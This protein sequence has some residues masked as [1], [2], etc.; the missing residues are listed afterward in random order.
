MASTIDRNRSAAAHALNQAKQIASF[1]GGQR[2]AVLRARE[3][4]ADSYKS[5]TGSQRYAIRDQAAKLCSARSDYGRSV[6][7]PAH[8]GGVRLRPR[9]ARSAA[10]VWSGRESNLGGRAFLPRSKKTFLMRNI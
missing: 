8:A 2:R 5:T 6:V 7:Q 3:P 9:R 1:L 4:I 10:H